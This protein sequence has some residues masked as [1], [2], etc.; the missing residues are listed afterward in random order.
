MGITVNKHQVTIAT[1]ND[2]WYDA[3]DPVTGI[4]VY[5]RTD[6]PNNQNVYATTADVAKE[7]AQG[8]PSVAAPTSTLAPQSPRRSSPSPTPP[9]PSPSELML[10]L[11]SLSTKPSSSTARPHEG[12]R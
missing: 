1:T 10:L 2:C 7:L 6:D 9:T 4:V 11:P 3:F 8:A 12:H 5:R